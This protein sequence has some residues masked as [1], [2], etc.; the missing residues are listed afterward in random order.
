MKIKDI[1]LYYL[2]FKLT[3]FS[4][5]C[6][7]NTFNKILSLEGFEIG[8]GTFFYDPNSMT[9]DRERPWMLKIGEYCKITK[10][11]IL[12]TH[13]YSRSVMRRKYGEII[14]EAG[15]TIIGD[16]VF[17]GMNSIVLMGSSIGNNVIIGAGSVVSG[18]IPDDVVV[19]GNP[20][21]V[22]RTLEEHY[23]RRKIK[24]IEEAKLYAR[25]FKNK[26]TRKPSIKEMNA[27]FPLYLE[28]N[29]EA[30]LRSGVNI[31]LNGDNR[32]EIL[33]Y[34]LKSKAVY[35]SFEEFL[36]DSL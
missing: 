25:E 19:A 23:L 34:F 2:K 36:S 33:N 21:K 31:N 28:R 32:D 17:I 3:Y 20:A 12:L 35:S 29:V 6:K 27:F 11:T 7:P 15:K 14:G 1:R 30:I 8:K 18:T 5:L 4:R 10:G 24:S 16:N 26:Y 9:I 13:D 22:I